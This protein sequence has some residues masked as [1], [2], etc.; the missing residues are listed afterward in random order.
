MPSAINLQSK[1]A[2]NKV[3]V[4]G[5][6]GSGKS[7]FA[8]SAPTPGFVIDVG[9]EILSYKKY[10]FDYEQFNFNSAGW[11]KLER[12]MKGIL[13]KTYTTEDPFNENKRKPGEGKEYKTI[14]LDNLTALSELAMARA[15]T[16]APQ[17][18]EVGGP[19][20]QVHY[21]LASTLVKGFL[22]QF[23]SLGDVNRIAI[24][25]T[26]LITNADGAVV[27]AEPL[28]GGRLPT[29]IPSFF[30]EVL[31]AKTVVKA[32]PGGKPEVNYKLQ[33]RNIGNFPARSRSS[34]KERALP[35]YIDNNWDSLMQ[36]E[37]Q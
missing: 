25:H 19:L 6:S 22:R 24:A 26:N 15:L 16:V 4:I 34:G 11:D 10:D 21:K 27:G 30:D 28:L 2:N 37:K 32:K 23:L 5:K 36:I 14:V 9:E 3:I 8:C 20:W 33:T 7:H 17:R 29:V 12:V 18:D 35:D 13:N 1:N 31:Y